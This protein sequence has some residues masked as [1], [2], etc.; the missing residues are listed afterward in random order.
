M[1]FDVDRY[2]PAS[3]AHLADTLLTKTWAEY[4]R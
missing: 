1:Y 4:S 2:Q 3:T